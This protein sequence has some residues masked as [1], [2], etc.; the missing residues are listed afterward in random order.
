MQVMTFLFF[1]DFSTA[2]QIR[3]FQDHSDKF[4]ASSRPLHVA[5]SLHGHLPPPLAPLTN[6]IIFH[7]QTNLQLT[8]AM[9]HWVHRICFSITS[10]MPRVWKMGQMS[11]APFEG[12]QDNSVILLSKLTQRRQGKA[13]NYL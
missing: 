3:R 13:E 8:S 11:W 12:A 2:D 9:M 1:Q 5:G 6:W 7:A 4:I 10:S